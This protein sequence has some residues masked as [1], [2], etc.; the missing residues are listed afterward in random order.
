M[1]LGPEDNLEARYE[2]NVCVKL[3]KIATEIYEM[4]T[5]AYGLTYVKQGIYKWF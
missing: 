5:T 4:N 2:I 1:Q 3:V